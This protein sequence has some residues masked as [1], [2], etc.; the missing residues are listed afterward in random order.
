MTFLTFACT[1]LF[2]QELVKNGSFTVQEN[3]Q[4]V[5]PEWTIEN[6]AQWQYLN[7]DGILQG[8]ASAD[9]LRFTA[10]GQPPSKATQK[11]TLEAR[12][13][14]TL[15][16]SY[17]RSGCV[18]AVRIVDANGKQLLILHGDRNLNEL[19]KDAI[20]EFD[21]PGG[22]ANPVTLELIGAVGNTDGFSCFDNVSLR[23]GHAAQLAM[24]NS[25]QAAVKPAGPNIAKGKTYTF[26]LKPNYSY[27]TDK[28]DAIQLTDGIYSQGYFWVQKSTVGWVRAPLVG[29]TI[30]LGKEEP[31]CGVSWNTAAGAAD[32]SWPQGLQIFTSNDKENWEHCGDLIQLTAKTHLPPQNTYC[33]FRYATNELKSKGRYIQFVVSST[34]YTFVDEIE[35][36]RGPDNWLYELQPVYA[37]KD[38]KELARSRMALGSAAVRM[39]TDLHNLMELLERLPQ[40]LHDKALSEARDLY[41]E[42]NEMNDLQG[43][44][45]NS[46]ELPLSPLHA[47]IL[48]LNLYVLQAQ[49][50]LEPK[51]WHNVRWD[52]LSI[53]A[54]P[55]KQEMA[56]LEVHL[57]RGEVRGETVNIT[58]P[59]EIPI[60]VSFSVEGLPQGANLKFNEV[61]VT[62]TKQNLPI[63]DALRPADASGRLVVVVPAGCTRQVWLSFDKPTAKAGI[64]HANIIACIGS[65][66]LLL[67]PEIDSKHRPIKT[68]LTLTIYDKDF[69]TRP[70]MHVG[71]WD[72]VNGGNKYYKSPDNL[73]PKLALM[74]D[75]YVDSPWATS[76][77]MPHGAVFDKEGTLTNEESLDYTN[78][79]EW[80]S[81]FP[82]ARNYCV[83]WSVGTT[84]QR[85]KMGTPMFEKK[86]GQYLNAWCQYLKKTGVKPKQLVILLL[87]EPHNHDQ[88]AIIIAWA[89]AIKATCPDITLFE[90]PTYLDPTKA[91]PEL[92]TCVDILC[93]HTPHRVSKGKSFRDFYVKQREDGRTLWLY[94]CNGPARHLDPVTYHRGQMWNA[95]DMGAVGTFYWALGCG[96]GIGNSFKAYHQT[97]LEYSPFFVSDTSVMQSKHSEAIREGVQ[98]Y[99]YMVMLRDRI[100]E[101]RKQGK[102]AQADQKQTVLD[103]SLKRVIDSI[104]AD[105][106]DWRREKDRS[107]MDQSRIAILK[108]LVD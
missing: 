32:V 42:T 108:A 76:A 98:D 53:T 18:P 25:S 8:S 73:V 21:A 4:S 88:D 13:Y 17:K 20:A 47:K 69:P 28:D 82:E 65:R 77:V 86:L 31:I 45:L 36:Y 91:L 35:V 87:D 26:T 43:K 104:I 16:Y 70:T 56:P 92:F 94:S 93:P 24:E 40:P 11:V 59:Y 44:E 9:C 55:P 99:E 60:G 30:D 63:A 85:E 29:I 12:K 5:P 79:N 7:Y 62:D 22:L 66:E 89:K 96:G 61:L 95:F 58:N 107:I 84:F 23:E 80:K 6:Q 10:N 33:T 27:C 67:K 52:N 83:F 38:P 37:I 46:T 97:G 2:A 74:K 106:M 14:Y 57:M 90:D 39:K 34:S 51:L 78:W 3:T 102:S 19:W 72:Y 41:V 50:L 48:A 105:G 49:G 103:A 100:A 81:L 15:R 75:I 101:L 1:L 68:K 54:I 64:Y 71:G